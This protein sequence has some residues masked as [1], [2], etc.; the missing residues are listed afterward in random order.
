[1]FTSVG[2]EQER[3]AEHATVIA[4]TLNDFTINGSGKS[5]EKI[6]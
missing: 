2:M 5:H 4:I 1:M 6:N 3:K